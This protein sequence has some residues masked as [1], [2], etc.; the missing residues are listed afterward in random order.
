MVPWNV[1]LTTFESQQQLTG[2]LKEDEE[3]VK[4]IIGEHLEVVLLIPT[5][6]CKDDHVSCYEFSVF[7]KWFGPFKG[8]LQRLIEALD[9]G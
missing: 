4:M 1:F 5:D 2:P 7:L 3:F 8:S 9:G 6:F